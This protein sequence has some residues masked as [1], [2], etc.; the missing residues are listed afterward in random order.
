MEVFSLLCA[1]VFSVL[2]AEGLV[3]WFDGG[4]GV[5]LRAGVVPVH[6]KSGKERLA[7][8]K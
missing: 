6:A 5:E 2:C 1:E 4:V 3:S 7:T 8:M